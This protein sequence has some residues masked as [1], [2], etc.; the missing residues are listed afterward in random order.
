MTNFFPKFPKSPFF[1]Q[2]RRKRAKIIISDEFFKW[3]TIFSPKSSY[4]ITTVARLAKLA[5]TLLAF[6]TNSVDAE[7]SFSRMNQILTSQREA[8]T[9]ENLKMLC[10]LNFNG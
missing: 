7:R 4:K 8:L 10:I 1:D 9:V 5:L 3:R 6:P 2:N